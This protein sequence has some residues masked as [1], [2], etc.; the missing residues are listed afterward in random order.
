MTPHDI[1][2][3]CSACKAEAAIKALTNEDIAEL[4]V[5]KAWEMAMPYGTVV[6][7]AGTMGLP[8]RTVESWTVNPEYISN[9]GAD[10][11]GRKGLGYEVVQFL[12]ALNG[13][14]SPG[15]QFLLL[16]CSLKVAKGEAI[17]GREQMQA[18]LHLADE[19]NAIAEEARALEAKS[20]AF[21]EKVAAVINLNKT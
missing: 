18:V 9:N 3:R 21:G 5:W 10:A 12:L 6:E 14:F 11:N 16:F 1:N 2:C 15:A 4:P 20:R 7:V 17:K 19:A 13:V 8:H